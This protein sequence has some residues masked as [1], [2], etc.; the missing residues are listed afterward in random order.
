MTS[1]IEALRAG[2]CLVVGLG[3]GGCAD[4]NLDGSGPLSQAIAGPSTVATSTTWVN[5]GLRSQTG[6]VAAV[7]VSGRLYT[8]YRGTDGLLYFT[9]DL[10]SPTLVPSSPALAEDVL[11]AAVDPSTQKVFVAA[12][13]TG[14]AGAVLEATAGIGGLAGW[15]WSY[16]GTSE[17]PPSLA[18]ACG[19]VNVAVRAAG[20][21][22]TAYRPASGG[23]WVSQGALAASYA[24]PILASNAQGEVGLALIGYDQNVHFWKK[25]CGGVG[26]NQWG[27]GLTLGNGS[28]HTAE[29]RV[30]LVGNGPVF[31]VAIRDTGGLPWFMQQNYSGVT[32]TT[33]WPSTYEYLDATVER[34]AVVEPPVALAFRGLIVLAA[35]DSSSILRYWVRNPNTVGRRA[36]FQM[37]L[38]ERQ[39][40]G[41]GLKT[42]ATLVPVAD[43]LNPALPTELLAIAPSVNLEYVGS[44]PV[45]GSVERLWALNLSRAVTLDLMVNQFNARYDTRYLNFIPASQIENLYESLLSAMQTPS[46]YWP[47]IAERTFTNTCESADTYRGITLYPHAS[48]SEWVTGCNLGLQY[49]I[50]VSDHDRAWWLWQEWGHTILERSTVL[51]EPGWHQNFDDLTPRACAANIDCGGLHGA[52]CLYTSDQRVGG[53]A[54][55]AAKSAKI[56]MVPEG[57]GWRPMGFGDD[58]SLTNTGHNWINVVTNYRWFGEDGRRIAQWD[59][60]NGDFRYLN[61]Y[62]WMRDHFYDGVEF[63]GST[64]SSAEDEARGHFSFPQQ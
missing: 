17:G 59:A 49:G 32:G 52:Q 19:R 35:R 24:Q 47:D 1:F 51:S 27:A 39:L 34:A 20:W 15:S 30:G 22:W 21:S 38:G 12:R 64:T 4:M 7:S 63:F 61:K 11:G 45:L 23:A 42:T 16:P 46:K 26:D 50:I 54:A 6:A 37:W 3:A 36:D 53:A 58:Y 44:P 13:T 10:A 25:P 9:T 56:C 48:G 60:D 18:V 31:G 5:T 8:F 43:V 57:G 40:G 55:A 41:L 29:S 28:I 2:L 14:N 62:N 33:S